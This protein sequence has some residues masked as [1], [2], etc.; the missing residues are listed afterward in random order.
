M[1]AVERRNLN[2]IST[3]VSNAVPADYLKRSVQY[4]R[5]TGNSCNDFPADHF[6]CIICCWFVPKRGRVG[7]ASDD[8][9]WSQVMFEVRHQV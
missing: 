2:I 1:L 6:N 8:V 4:F 9:T 7:R 5:A 3:H